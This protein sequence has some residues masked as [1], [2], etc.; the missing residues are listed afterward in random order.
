MAQNPSRTNILRLW[1]KIYNSSKNQKPNVLAYAVKSDDSQNQKTNV[2]A[3][4]VK[5]DDG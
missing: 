1:N 5:S 4:A 3:Y 2:L